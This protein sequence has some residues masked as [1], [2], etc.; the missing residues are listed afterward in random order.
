MRD[1]KDVILDYFLNKNSLKWQ[2][3]AEISEKML[4]KL[5]I[6]SQNLYKY[7]CDWRRSAGSLLY[8][9]FPEEEILL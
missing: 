6:S 8:N 9:Y 7:V 4:Q 2:K 5:D 1:C 3:S